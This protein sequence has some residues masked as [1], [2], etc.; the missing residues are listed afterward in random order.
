METETRHIFCKNC[1]KTTPHVQ[2][3]GNS[4]NWACCHCENMAEIDTE[5]LDQKQVI[6]QDLGFD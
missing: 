6:K 3:C 2:H 4:G 5:G 1:R